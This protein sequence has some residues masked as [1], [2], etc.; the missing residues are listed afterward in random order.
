MKKFSVIF[1]VVALFGLITLGS[2]KPKAT[3]PAAEATEQAAPEAEAPAAEEAP[4]EA[5]AAEEAPAE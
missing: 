1:A 3:E 2:C 5:P 4:A